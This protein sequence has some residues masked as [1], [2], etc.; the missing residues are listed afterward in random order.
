MRNSLYSLAGFKAAFAIA[1][2]LPRPVCQW[3]GAR[4][5]LA[6]YR[7]R[8][9]VQ[10]AL[11]ENLGHVTGRRGA[12]LQA[13]CRANVAGFGRMLADYFLCA[14]MNAPEQAG[15]LLEEW[16]GL[17]QLQAAR[18]RGRGTIVVTAHLGHWELGGV[19][20]ARHGWPVTVVTLEEPSSELTRWRDGCRRHLGIR[21]IAVGPG[22]PFSF[23]ELIQALRRNDLVAMLVDR[24]YAGTGA[25][26]RFF[27]GQ[28]EF[29]TAPALLAHHTGAAVLPAFVLQKPNGNYVSFAD[30]IIP[31]AQARDPR[32]ALRENTQRIATIFE[33][34]VRE[35]PEQWFNYVP[36]WGGPQP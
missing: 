33:A 7:H 16:R 23:I 1:Q 3:L 15:R 30:P 12:E 25:P 10:A 31:M 35:H 9:S 2:L 5:A 20:L 4:I 18:D 13:L 8:G 34:I 19:T 22:H 14:G 27:D 28:T 29:S 32:S 11:R 36:V 26:V 17:E 24:P 21:T 6:S